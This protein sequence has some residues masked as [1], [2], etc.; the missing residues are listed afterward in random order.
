MHRII[1][2]FSQES[3]TQQ[4]EWEHLR[5]EMVFMPGA[6]EPYYIFKSKQWSIES[7]DEIAEII[8]SLNKLASDHETLL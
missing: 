3:S 2:E 6:K 1:T 5:V 8:N 4:G 7:P